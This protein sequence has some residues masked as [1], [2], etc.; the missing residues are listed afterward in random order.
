MPAP[1]QVS[2]FIALY[3]LTFFF[4]NW[5]PNSITYILPSELFPARFR[6]TAHGVCA[7]MGKAGAI[8]GVF[9]FG[10]MKDTP[11]TNAGLQSALGL[12]TGINFLGLLCTYPIPEPMGRTLEQITGE[13]DLVKEVDEDG[14]STLPAHVPMAPAAAH[15]PP[16]PAPS[17]LMV[18][19]A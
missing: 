13:F 4:A 8:V 12:L 7:A 11:T 6:S 17:P 19:S 14:I 18:G 3:A 10:I 16:P 2:N 5:G 1:A 15:I 9:G